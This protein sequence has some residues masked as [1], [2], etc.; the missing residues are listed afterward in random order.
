MIEMNIRRLGELE[1][2]AVEA[3]NTLATNLFFVGGNMKKILITSCHPQEGKSF[4]SINLMR[5][6]ASLGLRVVLVDA[7]IRASALQGVYGIE[8]KMPGKEK[9]KGLTGYL[10]GQCDLED[11]LA[12][13]NIPGAHMIL[14]GRT[15]INSLPLLNTDRLGVLLDKLAEEYDVVLLDAPPI[16]AIIDAAKISTLCDGTL[17]VVQSGAD[18]ITELKEAARQIEKSGRPIIGYVINK[19]DAKKH[20]HGYYYSRK[21]NYYRSGKPKKSFNRLFRF[22]K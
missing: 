5:T 3:I 2:S 21:T 20:G 11:I 12:R 6:M 15:V 19:F 9:Y 18:T 10:F 16:G 13:T 8:I 17:F 22:L 1:Y 14:A 7:D 4:V